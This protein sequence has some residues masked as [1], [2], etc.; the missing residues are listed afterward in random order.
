MLNTQW[1]LDPDSV[2][3]D[4]NHPQDQSNIELLNFFTEQ[5]QLET[6]LGVRRMPRSALVDE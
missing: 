1:P 5:V 2:Q 3:T 4:T 6:Q